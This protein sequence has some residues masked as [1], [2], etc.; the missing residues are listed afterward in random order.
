VSLCLVASWAAAFAVTSAFAP[1]SGAA[2][3]A[4]VFFGFAAVCAAGCAFIKL[5]V[6]ETG[7]KQGEM[8]EL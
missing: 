3:P 8:N 1:L 5:L 6:P 7:G 4:A 2:G